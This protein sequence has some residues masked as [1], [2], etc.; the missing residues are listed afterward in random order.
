MLRHPLRGCDVDWNKLSDVERMVLLDALDSVSDDVQKDPQYDCVHEFA[1]TTPL[2]RRQETKEKIAKIRAE[3]NTPLTSDEAAQAATEAFNKSIQCSVDEWQ[4]FGEFIRHPENHKMGRRDWCKLLTTNNQAFVQ[5]SVLLTQFRLIHQTELDAVKE[6]EKEHRDTM[7]K[8]HM[9]ELKQHRLEWQPLVDMMTSVYESNSLPAE[10]A[11][12]KAKTTR[13]NN[14]KAFFTARRSGNIKNIGF[15]LDVHDGTPDRQRGSFYLDDNQV[16]YIRTKILP[17]VAKCAKSDE[18]ILDEAGNTVMYAR[19]LLQHI[20][21]LD[22]NLREV[23]INDFNRLFSMYNVTAPTDWHDKVGY[24]TSVAILHRE[25]HDA[26]A[27]QMKRELQTRFL[28]YK[29]KKENDR[30]AAAMAPLPSATPNGDTSAT[31]AADPDNSLDNG[32]D[33]SKS[34]HTTE[35]EKESGEGSPLSAD[36]QKLN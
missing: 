22:D 24:L 21:K 13:W 23:N 19:R 3:A 26:F 14:E 10:L 30:A 6:L 28:E 31:A 5:G 11:A 2:A 36:K 33:P 7:A 9:A 17:I 34:S 27:L 18:G 32:A 35:E 20:Y 15:N 25:Y 12:E 29:E 4:L 16:K 8:R 1:L